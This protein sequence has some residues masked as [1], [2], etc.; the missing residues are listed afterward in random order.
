[1]AIPNPKDVAVLNPLWYE[2]WDEE[3]AKPASFLIAQLGLLHRVRYWTIS[4]TKNPSILEK[5]VQFTT[6]SLPKLWDLCWRYNLSLNLDFERR[7]TLSPHH[8]DQ[9]NRFSKRLERMENETSGKCTGSALART[10]HLWVIFNLQD[11]QNPALPMPLASIAGY[12][13]SLSQL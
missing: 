4:S 7:L 5:E 8:A 13:I 11:Q 3:W 1:M 10:A 12:F 9:I 6:H 2:L